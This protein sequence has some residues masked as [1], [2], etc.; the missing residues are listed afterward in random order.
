M[1]PTEHARTGPVAVTGPVR[2][3]GVT[4]PHARLL[5]ISHRTAVHRHH[6]ENPTASDQ[7]NPATTR[8]IHT[9][10]HSNKQAGWKHRSD[11][12][13]LALPTPR[14]NTTMG[15]HHLQGRLHRYRIIRS[16]P[17]IPTTTRVDSPLSAPVSTGVLTGAEPHRLPWSERTDSA[18]RSR[19]RTTRAPGA[20]THTQWRPRCTSQSSDLDVPLPPHEPPVGRAHHGHGT[21]TVIDPPKITHPYLGL[22][23]GQTTGVHDVIDP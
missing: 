12:R 22:S 13:N 9:N 23:S 21:T 7:E 19:S 4:S 11:H 17:T 20:A 2:I 3:P 1:L 16:G 6:G 14:T 15:N 10:T 18:A 8:P 5:A